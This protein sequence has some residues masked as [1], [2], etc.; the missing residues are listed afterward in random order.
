MKKSL[1]ALAALTA[2]AGVASAQS[3][4]TLFGTVDVAVES[5]KTTLGSGTS[6]TNRT[7]TNNRR[8]TS[9]LSVTGAEDL[10]GGLRAIF[11]YEGDFDGT[12]PSGST[13]PVGGGGGEIFVGLAGGFGSLKLGTPNE[14]S[15]SSQAARQ[16][17]GTKLGSG[18]G[19]GGLNILGTTLVRQAKSLRYDTPNMGGVTLVGVLADGKKIDLGLNFVGGPVNVW[20]T[21]Y[22]DKS[23]VTQTNT[24]TELAVQV[25]FG[26]A[27][28]YAGAH[29]EANAGGVS[30]ADSKGKNV[31]FKYGITPTLYLLGNL[32]KLDIDGTTQDKKVTAF[33]GEYLLSKRTTVYGRYVSQTTSNVAATAQKTA[34]TL[35][36]GT[37]HNF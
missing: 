32:A 2:F 1:L 10:G 26:T 28:I 24:V 29:S 30:T 6:T 18:F 35:L 7:M 13:H 11:L 15:L 34:T 33:G 36:V 3:S 4:V 31:A 25:T 14:P 20:L 16:P 19:G 12:D 21:R 27:T 22:Q 9:Q 17:I 8:G 23:F 5:T 37:Q